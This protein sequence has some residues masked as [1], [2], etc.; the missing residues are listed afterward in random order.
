[1]FEAL[2]SGNS[3]AESQREVLVSDATPDVPHASTDF[4]LAQRLERAAERGGH[5]PSHLIDE[6]LAEALRDPLLWE[7]EIRL[8]DG[9]GQAFGFASPRSLAQLD[10]Q[11][12]DLSELQER[13]DT[14]AK[15]WER[16]LDDLRRENLT[17]FQTAHP[18]WKGRLAPKA[19][20]A[21]DPNERL[22]ETKQLLD[23]LV[24]FTDEDRE[25][26]ARLRNL[27]WKTEQ[28]MT[29][30]YRADVRL[31]AGLRIRAL[32]TEVAGRHYMDRYASSEERDAYSR[33]EACED[34]ALVASDEA[35]AR[36]PRRPEPFPTLAQEQRQLEAIVPGWLGMSLG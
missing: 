15:R 21:L 1:M 26:E 5:E 30:R 32:L 17:A 3:L 4:F 31:A 20:E 29:A 25:R 11:S 28:A 9:V 8:L 13:L 36:A 24:R 6:F 14:Y 18:E 33:L 12:K 27:H 19:V 22:W 35:F 23:A 7:R 10:A 16:T 2:A 34:L